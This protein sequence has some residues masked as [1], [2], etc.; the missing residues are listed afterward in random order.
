MPDLKRCAMLAA[1][2]LASGAA[3]AHLP[4]AS[5][6]EGASWIAALLSISLLACG[7][8]A[9]RLWRRTRDRHALVRRALAFSS[10]TVVLA[11]LL[12]GPLDDLAATSFAAHMV[13][14]EGLMLV[15]APLLVVGHGLPLMLWSLPHALRLRVGGL[16]SNRAFSDAWRVLSSPLSAWLLH[17]AAL[18]LWHAPVLFNAALTRPAVHD[19]QHVSFLGTA[20]LFWHAL[21]RRGAHR[22]QGLAVLYLFTTT[23]HTGVLGAL[24]T[25]ARAPLY[26]PLDTGLI[27][28]GRLTPLEDQQLGGLIM[29]VPG[30]LVYAG[31]GLWL[32]ARWIGAERPGVIAS[33]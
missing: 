22:S 32:A 11:V 10:G 27:A 25:F 7:A 14:H 19:W 30:A 1:G 9:F 4:P 31:M 3:H 16:T 20:L 33:R 8:G 15:A 18:W 23:I 17:A 21:L 5:A 28:L 24:L 6:G 2:L 13:Q 29:W 26:A 12:L